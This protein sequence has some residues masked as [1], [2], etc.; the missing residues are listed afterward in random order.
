MVCSFKGRADNRALHRRRHSFPTRLS[1]D[2]CLE[3]LSHQKQT[4][5]E[6][7]EQHLMKGT[8]CQLLSMGWELLCLGVVWQPYCTGRINFTAIYR[9]NLKMKRDWLLQ[10]AKIHHEL[11]QEMK[12]EAFGMV[13][14]VL[15][16]L[17]ICGY[18]VFAKDTGWWF[19][20]LSFK[21]DVGG[22]P[23]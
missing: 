20:F 6:K 2:L 18:V 12:A 9:S 10:Q 22:R 1:S 21:N 4:F 13:L 11:L 19:S 23:L 15:S 7:K 8:P 3:S 17:K 14:S 5:L 16:N